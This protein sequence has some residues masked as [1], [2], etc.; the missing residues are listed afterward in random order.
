MQ[1]SETKIEAKANW[2]DDTD[3]EEYDDE[4]EPTTEF[5]PTAA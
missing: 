5:T 2:A 3:D 4:T 1:T